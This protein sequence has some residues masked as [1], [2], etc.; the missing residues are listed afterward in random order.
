MEE[1]SIGD[2]EAVG[3][4]VVRGGELYRETERDGGRGREGEVCGN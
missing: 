3:K 1:Q 4:A 2:K